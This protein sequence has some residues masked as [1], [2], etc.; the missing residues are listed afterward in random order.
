M[1]KGD[2]VDCFATSIFNNVR[3][4]EEESEGVEGMMMVLMMMEVGQVMIA[5]G[6]FRYECKSVSL[7]REGEL[8]YG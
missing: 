7:D 6:C 5:R 1:E 4:I 8:R 2:E 3:K